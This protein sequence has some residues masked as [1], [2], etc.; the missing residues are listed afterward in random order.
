MEVRGQSTADFSLFSQSKVLLAVD[1]SMW[2]F[3][4][5]KQKKNKKNLLKC[6]IISF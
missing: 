5:K 4:H 2:E 1:S 3:K 6:L